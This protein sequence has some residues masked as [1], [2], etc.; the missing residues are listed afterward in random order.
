MEL[1][2]NGINAAIA[3]NLAKLDAH[4]EFEIKTANLDDENQGITQEVLDNTDVLLWW[5]HMYHGRVDD[6]V[7]ELVKNQ[8]H[9]KGLGFFCLHSG[10]YSKTFKAVLG[11]TGHLKGGWREA[12]DKESI[13]VCNPWHPI[14]EGVTDFVIEA[15][16]M[17]GAPFDVPPANSIIFQSHFSVGNETFPSGLVWTV[18]KG[19]DPEFTSGPGK[20]VH[21]GEG[22]G[23]VFY[24][25]PGHET[26]PTYHNADVLK[27]I[28]NGVR[29]LGKLS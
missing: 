10:H 4:N 5:G 7:A 20:G 3:E 29:W 11:A 22:I 16:E 23:R 15:E 27:V 28:Y 26:Y 19:V 14:T 24:F 13:R 25:R 8:V 18:G 6:S 17:Y 21:Q 12:D 1:Y 9:E 2:P